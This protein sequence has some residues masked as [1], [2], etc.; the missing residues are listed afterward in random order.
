VAGGDPARTATGGQTASG[1][2]AGGGTAGRQSGGSG[3]LGRRVGTGEPASLDG[4]G[5]LAIKETP[6]V[7]SAPAASADSSSAVAAT[8]GVSTHRTSATESTREISTT[9]AADPA[10]AD[11]VL[12][13][14]I[15]Q[16]RLHSGNVV[17]SLET[18][19]HDPQ[20]GSLRLVLL[21]NAGG[22]IHAELIAADPATADA[23]SR[24]AE[25]AIGGSFSLAGID[26]RIRSEGGSFQANTGSHGRP[27]ERPAG[28][29]T[30][31]N[32]GGAAGTTRHDGGDDA[33]PDRGS[34]TPSDSARLAARLA[35]V[36]ARSTAANARTRA[37]GLD[38]W[39]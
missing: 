12:A 39:A 13:Q 26:L 28:F 30:H 34:K 2:T 29:A 22:T 10:K 11:R 33:G 8:Q 23:I 1:D 15:G 32:G 3:D 38:V 4:T 37:A 6:S 19:F 27:D 14:V 24:A 17:P 36:I 31:D 20:L 21:G 16:I 7:V 5:E 25:R 9:T 18:R 35:P